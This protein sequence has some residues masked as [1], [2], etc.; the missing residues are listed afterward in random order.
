MSGKDAP[1]EPAPAEELH[2]DGLIGHLADLR[3][4]V[5]RAVLAVLAVFI[6]LL[7]FSEQ[8]FTFF[9]DPLLASLQGAEGA[10]V[11]A[12][13]VLDPF[14]VPL[15]VTFF[16]AFCATVPYVLYQL[17]RFVAPGLYRRE[18]LLVIPIVA[19]STL[20]FYLGMAFAY[21]LVFKLVFEFIISV[22]PA[23]IDFL[24]DSGKYFSFA[25]TAF[26]VFGFAF[27]VPVAVF[28][29]VR[30]RVVS[31]AA[32]RSKRPYVIAGSFIVAAIVTPP[33]VISQ[34]LLAIPLCILYE[35]GIAFAS[36]WAPAPPAAEEET[37]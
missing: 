19:T 12:T 27:E 20:L 37:A 3:S 21:L 4:S 30:A 26:L 25:L 23:A 33:D 36:I 17:W 5:L 11:I 18:R 1:E 15:K 16:V 10:R 6:C 8:V 7:P 34:F 22:A 35:L 13:G 31:I 24:P 9:A 2:E 14:I 29:L 28:I 32:L